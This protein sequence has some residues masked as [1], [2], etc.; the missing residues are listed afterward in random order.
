[1][2]T[3]TGVEYPVNPSACARV[4]AI[5]RAGVRDALT[6]RDQAPPLSS[7]RGGRGPWSGLHVCA[8]VR[9]IGETGVYVE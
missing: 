1:M 7:S 5:G 2:I 6:P 9:A 8:R 4:R 3:A